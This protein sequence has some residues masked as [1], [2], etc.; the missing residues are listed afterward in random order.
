MEYCD[1]IKIDN[2]TVSKLEFVYDED[3]NTIMITNIN[4]KKEFE[5]K[6]YASKL[7]RK[8]ISF[9]KK[10]G[11]KEIY[12]DDMSDNYRKSSNIYRKFGFTYVDE[13]GPEMVLVL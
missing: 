13:Y 10:H 3:E 8:L 12:V 11:V 4:T 1:K 9:A 7:L 6:G 2:K 5:G